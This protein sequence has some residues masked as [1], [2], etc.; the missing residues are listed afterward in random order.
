MYLVIYSSAMTVQ[1][2]T[3]SKWTFHGHL[4]E[5][6][7]NQNAQRQQNMWLFSFKISQ[8]MAFR[9]CPPWAAWCHPPCQPWKNLWC[10]SSTS[11][12]FQH[13]LQICA[14]MG[15]EDKL[16]L[17]LLPFTHPCPHVGLRHAMVSWLLPC[18]LQDLAWPPNSPQESLRCSPDAH[19][20]L[21]TGVSAKCLKCYE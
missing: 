2:E 11:I 9:P 17:L 1:T 14:Q 6:L 21:G 18:M 4:I 10:L 5:E 8:A 16:F 20:V 15:G 19:S 12:C 13:P 7:K 3:Q